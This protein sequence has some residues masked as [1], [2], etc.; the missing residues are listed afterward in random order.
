[1]TKSM[2]NG[3]DSANDLIT[4]SISIEE[5]GRLSLPGRVQGGM[6]FALSKDY[7]KELVGLECFRRNGNVEYSVHKVVLETDKE[8]Y[9][10][11]FYQDG[12]VAD[13]WFVQNLPSKS[14]FLKKMLEK[15][16]TLEE[17]Q[18]LDPATVIIDLDENISYHRFS[19]GTIMEICYDEVDGKL[20]VSDYHISTDTFNA[21]N[22]LLDIDR[23]MI[24]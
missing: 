11:I 15:D 10:F 9:C 19:D 8:V 14:R 1:M 20:V 21:V 13:S 5:M 3:L 16:V 24:N 4:T 12:I 17:I 2:K 6:S 23:E 22:N 18:L 7:V